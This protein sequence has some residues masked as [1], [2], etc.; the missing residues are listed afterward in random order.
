MLMVGQVG[1]A[2]E[3]DGGDASSYRKVAE[4]GARE[5]VEGVAEVDMGGY[6]DGEGR[7]GGGLVWIST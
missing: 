6:L 7:G 1:C 3:G 4:A 5:G 2:D